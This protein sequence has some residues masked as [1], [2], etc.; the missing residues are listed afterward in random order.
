MAKFDKLDYVRQDLYKEDVAVDYVWSIEYAL[1]T[2][3][4]CYVAPYVASSDQLS[5]EPTLEEVQT[6]ILALFGLDLEA[7]A[8]PKPVAKKK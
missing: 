1:V 7:L 6:V 5:S 8:E 4:G 2:E 3:T